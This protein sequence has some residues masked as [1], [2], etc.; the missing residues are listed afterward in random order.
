M[1]NNEL[2]RVRC[3]EIVLSTTITTMIT[4]AIVKKIEKRETLMFL[5]IPAIDLMDGQVVRLSRGEADQKTVYSDNPARTACDFEKAGARRLHVVDLDGAFGGEPANL[6]AVKSI[7]ESV[8]MEIELGGGLR[9][10][11][12]IMR[13]LDLGI[14]YVILGT[15][16]LRRKDL[17][18]GLATEIGEKLIVG[19]D[20]RDGLVAVEGWVE[21]SDLQA[22]DFAGELEQMGVGTIIHTDISTDGMMTGPSLKPTGDLARGTS[23]NVIAS[24]GIRHVADLVALHSLRLPNL[25]GAISG[26]A[27]Y[28]QTLDIAEAVERLSG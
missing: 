18:A 22:H 14:D 19:I 12:T 3:S 4:I 6:D 8:E 5:P 21:T 25:I 20:A 28:E 10:H 1:F 15:S 13:V 17:V 26:R 27:V 11:D 7:R 9:D 23:M 16:A 24:G 2:I